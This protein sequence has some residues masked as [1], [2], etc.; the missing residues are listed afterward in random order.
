MCA[1]TWPEHV[2]EIAMVTMST[3][4]LFL[5]VAMVAW[6]IK[7]MCI[8]VMFQMLIIVNDSV[9]KISNTQFSLLH[10]GHRYLSTKQAHKHSQGS[11]SESPVHGS[12]LPPDT[13]TSPTDTPTFTPFAYKL[14]VD[15]PNQSGLSLVEEQKEIGRFC[16]RSIS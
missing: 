13:P 2:F 1:C 11:S 15:Q 12:P 8:V 3:S 7:H 16:D 9:S 14:T 4:S 10:R 5:A 6:N